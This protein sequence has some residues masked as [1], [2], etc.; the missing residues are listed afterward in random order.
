MSVL[1][2]L[3]LICMFGGGAVTLL[4]LARP[5]S[6]DTYAAK[7]LSINSGFAL[8]AAGMLCIV[9]GSN[10]FGSRLYNGILVAIMLIVLALPERARK[11]NPAK[12]NSTLPA[13]AHIPQNNT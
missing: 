7:L 6:R 8:T 3:E 5:S 10:D 4:S 12:P 2:A 1:N 11:E 9:I 13:H